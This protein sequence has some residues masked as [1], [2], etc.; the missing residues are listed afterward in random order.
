MSYA[1]PTDMERAFPRRDLVALT[2]D[3]SSATTINAAFLQGYLDDASLIIDAHLL[4]RFQLP[5]VPG[6]VPKVLNKICRDLTMYALQALRPENDLSDARKRH[7]DAMKMLREIRDGDLSLGLDE[8][9]EQ[10]EIADPTVETIGSGERT[11]NF[12]RSCDDLS[13]IFSRR[14]LAGF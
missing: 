11:G 8:A 5:F 7:E 6:R 14:S 2:N 12:A 13:Q 3:D 4:S 10:P 1:T 9:L